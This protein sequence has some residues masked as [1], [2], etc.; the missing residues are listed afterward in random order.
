MPLYTP[1]QAILAVKSAAGISSQF[2]TQANSPVLTEVNGKGILISGAANASKTV[3]RAGKALPA[4]DTTIIARVRLFGRDATN[5]A[6]IFVRDSATN[7]MI[8]LH[9]EYSGAITNYQPT[10]AS[11]SSDTVAVT[12]FGPSPGSLYQN[13]AEHYF[14]LVYTHSG[15]TIEGYSSNDG[16]LWSAN[17]ITA[18]VTGGT[19]VANPDQM[20]ICVISEAAAAGPMGFISVWNDGGVNSF[21]YDDTLV[22]A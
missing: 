20:G 15:K 19:Y 13:A 21:T 9:L 18:G 5:R 3:R 2:A 16:Q 1:S 10:A 6:G 7:R 22:F 12:A 8:I 14:K 4:A 17:F 11:Y